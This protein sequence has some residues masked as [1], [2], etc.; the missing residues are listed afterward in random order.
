[1]FPDRGSKTR[2]LVDTCGSYGNFAETKDLAVFIPDLNVS[3]SKMTG[4]C[5]YPP[6]WYLVPGTGT[7]LAYYLQ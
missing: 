1:M 3:L 6:P 4:T 5:R 7:L 2:Y